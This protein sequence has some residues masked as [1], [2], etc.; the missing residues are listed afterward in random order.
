VS[1]SHV[2]VIW[3]GDACDMM[4]RA[5][6]LASSPATI[7]NMT[8]PEAVSVR[9][10]A[11]LFSDRLKRPLR[12]VGLEGDTALLADCAKT[13]RLL[14]RPSVDVD[15]LVDWIA[16]WVQ[17]EGRTLGK[18]THFAEREGRF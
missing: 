4:L 16:E 14:G 1:V 18:P 2:N 13:Y 6:P 7:V 10:V 5:L 8:G 9:H 15:Q 11:E 12:F 3:Q 17:I